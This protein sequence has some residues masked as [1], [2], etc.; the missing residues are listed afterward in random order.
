MAILNSVLPAGVVRLTV[1]DVNRHVEAA[2]AALRRM[3]Y[4][5]YLRTAHWVR[6]RAFALERAGHICE[7]CGHGDRLEVHHRTC[8]RVGFEQPEDLIAFVINATRTITAR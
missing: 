7:L 2:I 4:K 3:P 6:Q 8:A 5:E 1:H